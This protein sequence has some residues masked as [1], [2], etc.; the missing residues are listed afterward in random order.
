MRGIFAALA[1]LELVR[2]IFAFCAPRELRP[3]RGTR[4]PDQGS[5][6][7]ALSSIDRGGSPEARGLTPKSTTGSVGEVRDRFGSDITLRSLA[8]ARFKVVLP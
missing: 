3:I 1:P 7:L 5:D 8:T 6:P 4:R 2:G